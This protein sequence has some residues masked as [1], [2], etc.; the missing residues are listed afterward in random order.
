[1]IFSNVVLLEYSYWAPMHINYNICRGKSYCSRFQLGEINSCKMGGVLST[2][3][4]TKYM[5]KQSALYKISHIFSCVK[6]NRSGKVY[7]SATHAWLVPRVWT[8][9]CLPVKEV[10]FLNPILLFF[11]PH[12]KY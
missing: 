3:Y 6:M 7:S 4:V 8:E 11:S 2:S 1:V 12:D 10:F 9:K 5:K